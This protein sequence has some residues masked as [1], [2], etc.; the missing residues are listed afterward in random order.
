MRL[1]EQQNCCDRNNS[2]SCLLPISGSGIHTKQEGSRG[3]IQCLLEALKL[4]PDNI[5]ARWLLNIAYMTVGEYP[6][7]FPAD[8]SSR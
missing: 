7:K 5:A 4:Q 3:A 6:G 8:G 1:G 2:R